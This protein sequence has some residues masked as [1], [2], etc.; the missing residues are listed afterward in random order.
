MSRLNPSLIAAH[1]E[2]TLFIPEILTD[3]KLFQDPPSPTC[4]VTAPNINASSTHR[5][6]ICSRTTDIEY[7]RRGIR[8]LTKLAQYRKST[9]IHFLAKLCWPSEK[10]QYLRRSKNFIACNATI[11]NESWTLHD[12][13]RGGGSE[14]KTYLAQHSKAEI[15]QTLR[16]NI[17]ESFRYKSS[18][19]S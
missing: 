5:D 3:D 17:Y 16:R 7:L 4:M 2:N 6:K 10:N 13:C 11:S 14:M 9:S 1:A 8:S 12:E 18:N 15:V 19:I